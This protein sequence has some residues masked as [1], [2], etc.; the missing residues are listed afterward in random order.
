LGRS[1]VDLAIAAGAGGL[2]DSDESTRLFQ[3]LLRLEDVVIN[4][5]RLT[6][7]EAFAAGSLDEARPREHS[8]E[9]LALC[10]LARHVLL[11]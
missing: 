2:E 7:L 11:A 4:D 6:Q 9:G 3:E 1:L 5:A 10:V 8:F